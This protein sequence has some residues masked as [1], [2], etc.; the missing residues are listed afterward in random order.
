MS[1]ST[2]IQC[3]TCGYYCL[4][5]GGMGCIDKPFMC[6]VVDIQGVLIVDNIN[7]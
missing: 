3:P 1:E 5:H 4:G 7:N 2:D 6:G